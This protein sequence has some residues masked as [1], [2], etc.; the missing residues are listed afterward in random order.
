M[1]YN[2]PKENWKTVYQKNAE[3]SELSWNKRLPEALK[4]IFNK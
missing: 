2:I 3:H 1:K 4:F